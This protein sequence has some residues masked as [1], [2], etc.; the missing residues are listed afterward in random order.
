MDSP[1]TSAHALQVTAIVTA[2]VILTSGVSLGV[3]G[4]TVDMYQDK[5]RPVG[6][7][8]RYPLNT[9]GRI[10]C[11]LILSVVES[12]LVVVWLCGWL[13]LLPLQVLT[14]PASVVMTIS[15][16]V[17]ERITGKTPESYLC[18]DQFTKATFDFMIALARKDRTPSWVVEMC[19]GTK[20]AEEPIVETGG[21]DAAEPVPDYRDAGV[22]SDIWQTNDGRWGMGHVTEFVEEPAP[23]YGVTY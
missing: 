2:A 1:G 23:T 18:L 20:A 22:A 15:Q 19:G 3:F 21:E 7:K 10:A 13:A 11:W 17:I 12:L 5:T 9:G 4:V 6:P 14:I 16:L 8:P